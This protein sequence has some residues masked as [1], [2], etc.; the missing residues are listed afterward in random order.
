MCELPWWKECETLMLSDVSVDI[1]D[2]SEVSTLEEGIEALREAI[3][4]YE[5][6]IERCL[7]EIEAAQEMALEDPLAELDGCLYICENA[8]MDLEFFTEILEDV[9]MDLEELERCYDPFLVE[10]ILESL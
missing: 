10:D 4:E 5:G 1:L 3:N 8:G 2:D 9:K 6:E 7:S